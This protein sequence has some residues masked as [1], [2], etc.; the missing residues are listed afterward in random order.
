MG[1]TEL[2]RSFPT[3]SG[4]VLTLKVFDRPLVLLLGLSR[5][6]I[7]YVQPPVF[8]AADDIFRIVTKSSTDLA[9]CILVALKLHFETLISSIVHSNSRIVAGD[10]KFNLSIRIIRR[11]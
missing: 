4:R 1:Y 10:Q 5:S 9:A 8:A 2:I 7:P 3:A 11:K 6:N